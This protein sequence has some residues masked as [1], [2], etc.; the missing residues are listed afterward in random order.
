M[1][2]LVSRSLLRPLR[3]AR[4]LR[5]S[6]ALAADFKPIETVGVVG[7]GSM[8]HGVAQVPGRRTLTVPMVAI[9]TPAW[10]VLSVLGWAQASRAPGAAA[11][12]TRRRPPLVAMW[13]VS[14][15]V[16]DL[17]HL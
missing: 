16:R 2:A 9:S 7:L 4:G 6:A 13:T 15:A 17:D 10:T 8:G 11:A 12:C 1:A 14:Q 5:T 3:A